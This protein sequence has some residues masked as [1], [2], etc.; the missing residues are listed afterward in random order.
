MKVIDTTIIGLGQIGYA[1][2][3]DNKSTRTH[4]GQI[5]QQANFKLIAACDSD[6]KKTDQLK[7][8]DKDNTKT[9]S[10]Y[11]TMLDNHNIELLVLAVPSG[12]KRK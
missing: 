7:N 5:K 2:D 9:Y 10:N 6:V 8:K 1:Y 11:K 4:V 12:D 3:C